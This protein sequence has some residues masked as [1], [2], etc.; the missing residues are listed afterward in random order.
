MIVLHLK[1]DKIYGFG[2]FEIVF[3]Y[4]KKVVNSII[5]TE[6]LTGRERVRCKKV[7]V[8]MSSNTT[9]KTGLGKA[10]MKI[11]SFIN[12]DPALLN[13]MAS[14]SG[15]SFCIDW[16]GLM[17]SKCIYYVEGSCEEQLIHALKLPPAKLIPGKVKVFN[18]SGFSRQPGSSVVF[19]LR[20]VAL[21][22][23]ENI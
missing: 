8:L 10:L 20:S 2:S 18:S 4:P 9:G 19:V 22:K 23:T 3:T 5:E 16:G 13:D 17:N 14:G 11:F 1:L 15:A 7:S 21:N 6:H 12:S